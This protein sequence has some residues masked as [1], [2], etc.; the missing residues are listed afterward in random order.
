[1]TK[2]I[3]VLTTENTD[4]DLKV[5]AL[6]YANELLARVRLSFQELLQT[7]LICGNNTEKC[8]GNK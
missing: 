3:F 8:L 1:M 5:V 2:E 4:L 7:R 6:H